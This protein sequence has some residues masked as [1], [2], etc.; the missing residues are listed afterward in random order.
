M[1][2]AK[3]V[4]S[5]AEKDEIKYGPEGESKI[6]LE[7]MLKNLNNLRKGLLDNDKYVHRLSFISELGDEIDKRF[8]SLLSYV[9]ACI[10]DVESKLKKM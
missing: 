10:K 4:L 8:I 9:T 3:R 1:S 5:L 6:V 2:L 7:E